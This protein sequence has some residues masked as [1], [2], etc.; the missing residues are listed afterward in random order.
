MRQRRTR[1]G[2]PAKAGVSAVSTLAKA[3]PR[4]DQGRGEAGPERAAL[5]RFKTRTWDH[6]PARPNTVSGGQRIHTL[7]MVYPP[8]GPERMTTAESVSAAGS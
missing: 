2:V 4:S 3:S 7:L 1:T 5:V 6:A 8:S